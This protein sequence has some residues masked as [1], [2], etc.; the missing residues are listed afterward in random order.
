M[1][2]NTMS[3]KRDR[4]NFLKLTA[5]VGSGLALA[6][7][8]TTANGQ[9]PKEDLTIF[10]VFKKRRS[11]RKFKSTPVPKEHITKILEAANRA[12]SA[13]NSQNWKFLVIRDRG[14]L[15]QLKE[16]CIARFLEL[17]KKELYKKKDKDLAAEELEEKRKWAK[18]YYEDYLSAP[19]YIEVLVDNRKWSETPNHMERYNIKDGTLAAAILL[20]AARA[21]GYGTVFCTDSIP[22]NLTQKMFNIPDHYTRICIT[23]VGVPENWPECPPKK[24]L[25]ELVVYDQFQESILSD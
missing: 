1:G 6:G 5:T 14:K 20:L 2:D 16:E 11:V 17:Y 22:E 10:E 24:G 25:D 7:M 8:N 21:L 13:G 3:L 9:I 23:P 4:R 12:P 19:V 15:N 18:Q